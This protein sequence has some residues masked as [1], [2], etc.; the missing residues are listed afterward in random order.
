[1]T[2]AACLLAGLRCGSSSPS[3]H[4]APPPPPSDEAAAAASAAGE[5]AVFLESRLELSPDQREKTR[6]AALALIERNA[7]LAEQGR[8]QNR[9][10]L[11]SLR[12][13]QAR[14]DAEVL[15]LLTAEQSLKYLRLKQDFHQTVQGRPPFRGLS[16]ARPAVPTGAPPPPFPTPAPTVTPG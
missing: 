6:G 16:Q 4:G 7:K 2:L 5:V 1:L 9:R 13:S 14:F 12:Q 10:I 3:S 15:S 11:E 8:T